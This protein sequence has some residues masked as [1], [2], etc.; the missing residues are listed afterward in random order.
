MPLMMLTTPL[1]APAKEEEGELW[2]QEVTDPCLSAGVE[3]GK[4]R[5][6]GKRKRRREKGDER[7][8]QRRT[9]LLEQLDEHASAPRVTLG[10]LEEKGVAG[11]D[12][13]SH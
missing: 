12:R 10:R 2:L 11:S 7:K 3:E 8:R 9:C 1:G 6:D 4:R 13:E 5:R